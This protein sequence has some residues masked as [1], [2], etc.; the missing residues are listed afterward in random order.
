MVSANHASS[1]Q[2]LVHTAYNPDFSVT[3]LF[4]SLRYQKA[5]ELEFSCHKERQEHIIYKHLLHRFD[6]FSFSRGRLTDILVFS[7]IR[8]TQTSRVSMAFNP[9]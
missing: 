4:G 7:V 1:N 5:K 3:V 8:L 2:S 6:F 9:I